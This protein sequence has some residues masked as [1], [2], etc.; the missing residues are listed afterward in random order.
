MIKRLAAL[1][2]RVFLLVQLVVMGTG[3]WL[4]YT[5]WTGYW[6]TTNVLGVVAGVAMMVAPLWLGWRVRM[7]RGRWGRRVRRW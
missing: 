7:A 2:E 5:S 4:F 1:P 3:L 6:P